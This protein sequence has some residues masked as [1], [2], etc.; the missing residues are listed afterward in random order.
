MKARILNLA[1]ATVARAVLAGSLTLLLI[2]PASANQWAAEGNIALNGTNLT[3]YAQPN[4]GQCHVDCVNNPRCQG[5]TWIQGGTYASSAGG[6]CYLVSAVT[7]RVV[8]RGHV[9]MVK[10][11]VTPP[12]PPPPNQWGAEGGTALNG[13]NL[14][15]YAQPSQAQCHLDCANNPRCQGATW[16][17]GG[18]YASSA[19]GMCYLLSAVTQ[20]VAARGHV[21]MVKTTA[22]TGGGPT[23]PSTNL[24]GTWRWE[25]QCPESQIPYSSGFTITQNRDTLGGGFIDGGGNLSGRVAGNQMEFVRAANQQVWRAVA[26]PSRMDGTIVRLT[27]G[28]PNCSFHAL[29]G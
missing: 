15:Y 1:A 24:A 27:E 11:A 5:A 10:T 16:I 7:Q 6:M 4:Q 26:T 14:T 23:G 9:S 2:T 28:K 18:T 22:G 25:A 21:S 19:G 20:R 17:Q 12:P 29:R 8:A 13:T 3:Y